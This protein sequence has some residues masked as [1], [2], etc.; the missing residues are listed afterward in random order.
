MLSMS[1]FPA[2]KKGVR[3]LIVLYGRALTKNKTEE[4]YLKD[5]DAG[6]TDYTLT[7]LIPAI[8]CKYI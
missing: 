8:L 3:D 5:R 4:R 1:I 6:D 7:V 2:I